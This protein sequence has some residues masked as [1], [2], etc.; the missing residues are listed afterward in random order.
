M[1]LNVY[2]QDKFY[3]KTTGLIFFSFLFIILAADAQ[4]KTTARIKRE[5]CATMEY[6][7]MQFKKFPGLRERFAEDDARFRNELTARKKTG[8]PVTRLEQVVTVPVV[9]HIVLKDPTQVTNEQ[10]M[11]QIDTINHDYAGLNGDSTKILNPFKPLFG[12]SQIQFCLAKRTPDNLPTDGIERVK[13]NIESFKRDG[14]GVGGLNTDMKH[15]NTGGADAWDTKKY[16]NIWVCVFSDGTLGFGTFPQT[17]DTDPKNQGVV[18]DYTSLPGGEAP[19]DKGRTLT[20]EIG[21]YFNLLHIWGDDDGACTGSDKIDDTPNQANS[22]SN[23]STIVVTD[24]C[25][26]KSP[27]ILF[28]DYMDYTDDKCLLLFTKDQVDVMEAALTTYRSSL[29]T[30]NGCQPGVLKTLNASLKNLIVPQFICSNSLP[31]DVTI[32]NAGSKTITSL[33]LNAQI[34]NG[35]VTSFNYTGSV[36]SLS[37]VIVNLDALQVTPGAHTLS[38]YTTKPNGGTDEDNI[39]DT[40]RTSF[41]YNEP[42]TADV[43]ESFEGNVFPP[44]GWAVINPDSSVTWKRVTGVGKTGNASVMINNF[45]YDNFDQVDYL[46]LPEVNITNTDS[47]FL[48]FQ[49]AA[50][51]YTPVSTPDNPFDTLKVLV[52]TDCGQTY[53][54]VYKKW[55]ASLITHK[56]ATTTSFK[57]TADEWRKDSINLTSYIPSEK[58][59]VTFSSTNEFENNIY[60][61]DINLR[62]VTVNPNLIREGFLVTPNPTRGNLLVQ[63]YPQPS[64]LKAI[65]VYSIIGQK[66]VEIKVTNIETTAYNIDISHSAAGVYIVRAVFSDKVLTKKIIKYQ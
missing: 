17:A 4:R 58:I 66:M 14:D 30:S 38:V 28:Q 9:F 63:F 39:N 7:E 49:V 8:S 16:L 64:N 55:G 37:S 21:H 23:C 6:L 61:D 22:S 65:Q 19:Y 12:K 25:S 60:L 20:H 34:D 59:I 47:V 10:I 48:T 5:K 36:A 1:I 3:M 50:A 51:A 11:A 18:I 26:T 54:S 32:F 43:K 44:E 33:I 31:S 56:G 53:K 27:G 62:R 52:S 13:T 57:P 42:L 35:N 24:A 46:R 40:V 29:I 45:E 2:V 15:T 41:V